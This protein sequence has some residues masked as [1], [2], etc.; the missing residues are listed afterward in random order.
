MLP[1]FHSRCLG[2][3]TSC[4]IGET[5]LKQTVTKLANAFNEG[6]INEKETAGN[7]IE[8][9]GDASEQS[10][11]ENVNSLPEKTTFRLMCGTRKDTPL[12]VRKA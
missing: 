10:M 11:E 9:P 2:T 5:H 12:T 8:E 6:L 3:S 4:P 1:L 7:A